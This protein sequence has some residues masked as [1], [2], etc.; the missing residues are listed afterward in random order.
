MKFFIKNIMLKLLKF[1]HRDLFLRK[2]GRWL[3]I[4]FSAGYI[5]FG[6]VSLAE[7][8]LNAGALHIVSKAGDYSAQIYIKEEE[9]GTVSD[10]EKKRD[11]ERSEI[12]MG[13][14]VTLTLAGKPQLISDVSKV[15]WSIEKGEKLVYFNGPTTGTKTVTLI[16]KNDL[17]EKGEVKVNVTIDNGGCLQLGLP[18]Q[19]NLGININ[20][21]KGKL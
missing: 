11:K 16:V 9:K 12:G 6:T 4:I 3:Q 13:E 19:Q 20:L 8:D 17:K 7:E 18:D 15:K 21:I 1:W 14:T 2:Y 5:V 10:K